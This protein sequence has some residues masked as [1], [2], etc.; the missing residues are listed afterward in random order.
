[1]AERACECLS[2]RNFH[3]VTTGKEKGSVNLIKAWVGLIRGFPLR[4]APNF[5][6]GLPS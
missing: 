2:V 4:V 1:M 6:T 5:P 3:V